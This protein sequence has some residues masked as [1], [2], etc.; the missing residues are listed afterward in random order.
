[1]GNPYWIKHLIN[2]T[3]SQRFFWARLTRYPIIGKMA[4]HA[5]FD[6][7][8]IF[9]LPKDKTIPI[10]E[11]VDPPGGIMAPSGIVEHFIKKAAYHW[12]MDFCI[13]RDSTRCKDY[14]IELGCLFLGEAVKEINPRFGRRV[15]AEEA[16]IHAQKCR[17][18]GLVHMI[19]KNKLDSVWLNAGPGDKLMTVCN[20]C[21]CCCLW[22]ILPDINPEISAKV[23]RLPGLTVTV[24]DRCV[25]CGMC[26]KDVCFVN[27]I[28]IKDKQASIDQGLCRGCGRCADIC[29]KGAIEMVLEDAAYA[30][31]MIQQLEKVVDVT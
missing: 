16:L 7:D 28:T 20:C 21:P 9:Y 15:T 5:L 30:S 22:K 8:A 3:F 24:S 2:K 29:P 4:D 6:G 17:E 26:V 12:I 1:M 25:G 18:A 23:N 13:C 14:P 11:A 19:G 31:R 27:A 10:N